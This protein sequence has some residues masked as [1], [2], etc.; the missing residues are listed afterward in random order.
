MVTLKKSQFQLVDFTMMESNIGLSEAPQN[1][2]SDSVKKI[3]MEY[4]CKGDFMIKKANTK[5]VY[6]V[7]T[8]ILVNDEKKM[9]GYQIYAEGVSIFEINPSIEEKEHAI[10]MTDGAV[11]IAFNNLRG[12]ISSSTSIYPLGSYMM[13]I[14][15]YRDFLER[16]MESMKENKPRKQKASPQKKVAPKK[17]KST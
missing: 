4:E 12:S 15:E 7:Y 3:M 6:L 17:K 9:P 5:G 10:L 14:F 1:T 11:P 13:P 8:R 16:K 2:D